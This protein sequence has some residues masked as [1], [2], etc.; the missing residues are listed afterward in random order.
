MYPG[1]PVERDRHA[2]VHAEYL[3][4]HRLTI[5][6]VSRNFRRDTDALARSLEGFRVLVRSYSLDCVVLRSFCLPEA[7]G[8]YTQSHGLNASTHPSPR[9]GLVDAARVKVAPACGSALGDHKRLRLLLP[10]QRTRQTAVFASPS[11]VRLTSAN[12]TNP[13]NRLGLRGATSQQGAPSE[14][15]FSARATTG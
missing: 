12:G 1:T 7:L 14:R 11:S 9:P 8:S 5:F 4:C 10:K 13:P 2:V 3:A 6:G 15:S